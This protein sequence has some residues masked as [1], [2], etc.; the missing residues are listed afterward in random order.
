[1]SLQAGSYVTFSTYVL[2]RAPGTCEKQGGQVGD[3]NELFDALQNKAHLCCSMFDG[4][5]G[6]MWEEQ[7]KLLG[8]RD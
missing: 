1:M 4:P 5:P 8:N 2:S 3:F 7:V 6:P